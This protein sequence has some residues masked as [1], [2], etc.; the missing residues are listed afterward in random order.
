MRAAV[1]LAAV[2]LAGCHPPGWDRAEGVDAAASVD[3]ASGDDAA[4]SPDA[5]LDA[6]ASCLKSFRLDGH[7]AAASVLVTGDFVAWAGTAADGAVAMTLGADAAWTA[8]RSFEPGT[9]QY[10]FVIDGTWLPDPA[11]PTTVDNG[12]GGVNSVVS[13]P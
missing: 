8:Q 7:G 5:S 12:L 13:C 10:R 2:T 11:N 9:Y 6:V 1:V 3:S 4:A